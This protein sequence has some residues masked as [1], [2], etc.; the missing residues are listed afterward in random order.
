M[1]MPQIPTLT[2]M[3]GERQICMLTNGHTGPLLH[4]HTHTHTHAYL[5]RVRL[6]A[7][8]LQE[9][10]DLLTERGQRASRR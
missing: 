5:A 6:F 7:Q 1:C 2:G 9:G 4:T 8:C 3:H 10:L